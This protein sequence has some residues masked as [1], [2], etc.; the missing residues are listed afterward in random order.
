M[1]KIKAYEIRVGDYVSFSQEV[2]GKVINKE[3]R[4][5]QCQVGKDIVL[6][7][8]SVVVTFSNGLIVGVSVDQQARIVR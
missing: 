2:G 7:M 3:I 6:S 1:L 8:E 5:K 4:S